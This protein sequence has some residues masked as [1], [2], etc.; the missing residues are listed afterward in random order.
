MGRDVARVLR[1]SDSIVD[2]GQKRTDT[3][4]AITIPADVSISQAGLA[5]L[6]LGFAEFKQLSRSEAL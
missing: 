2:G 1:L 5:P 6:G 4:P 3:A